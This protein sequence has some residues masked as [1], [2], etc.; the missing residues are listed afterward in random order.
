MREL[1]IDVIFNFKMDV[2]KLNMIAQDILVK[3]AANIKKV[4]NIPLFLMQRK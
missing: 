1:R 2:V 4:N 3:P